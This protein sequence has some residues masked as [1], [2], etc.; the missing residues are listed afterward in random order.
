[1]D[2]QA[3]RRAVLPRDHRRADLPFG[4]VVFERDPRG[5]QKR[6]QVVARPAQPLQPP[7]GVGIGRLGG[8]E[9]IQPAGTACGIAVP[10]GGIVADRRLPSRR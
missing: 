10:A 6:E 4:E 3:M 2:I 5:V 1:M 9:R 7:P 8:D